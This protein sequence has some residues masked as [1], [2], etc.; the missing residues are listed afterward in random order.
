MMKTEKSEKDEKGE[1]MKKVKRVKYVGRVQGEIS[2]ALK[3]L[4]WRSEGV[5]P[6]SAPTEVP[7]R[8]DGV[9]S[10]PGGGLFWSDAYS[11]PT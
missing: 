8:P 11:P 6:T 4:I 1:K 3:R 5:A 9:R 7:L 10:N 2:E